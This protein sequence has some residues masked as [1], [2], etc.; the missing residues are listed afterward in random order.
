[1]S[2]HRNVRH[3]IDEDDY[4]DDNYDDDDYYDEDYGGGGAVKAPKANAKAKGNAAKANS[5]T[6][7]PKPKPPAVVVVGSQGQ[8]ANKKV[9][10]AAAAAA[11]STISAGVTSGTLQLA[12]SVTGIGRGLVGGDASVKVAAAP[13]VTTASAGIAKPPPGFGGPPPP[14]AAAFPTPSETSA[15]SSTAAVG[16]TKISPAPSATT[17]TKNTASSKQLSS[18]SPAAVGKAAQDVAPAQVKVVT[19]PVPTILLE[20][21]QNSQQKPPLTLVVLGHV[22]AGKSTL[23][24]HLLHTC[25]SSSSSP[26]GS[27]TQ[28][29]SKGSTTALKTSNSNS[30]NNSTNI[31]FAWLLD[32]DEEERSHGVTMDIST[33]AITTDKY[34]VLLLDA[35]GHADYVPATITGVAAADGAL[36]VVDASDFDTAFGSG[37]L[38][39]HLYLCR[40]LGVQQILCV[41]NKMDACQPVPFSQDVYDDICARLT[42]F[43]TL[44]AGYA[45]NKIRFVPCAG[46]TGVNLV[47]Q[48]PAASA[49]ASTSA[50]SGS[51]GKGKGNKDKGTAAATPNNAADDAALLMS[52]YKGPTV[53]QALDGFDSTVAQS[54]KLQEQRLSKPLRILLQDVTGEQGKGVSVRAK[55]VQGWV[56]Q[57]ESV[58]VLPVGDTAVISKLTSLQQSSCSAAANDATAAA[59]D[60]N[61]NENDNEDSITISAAA[62]KKLKNATERQKYAVAGEMVDLVVTGVDLVRLSVGSLL[63]RA[64]QLPVMASQCRAKVWI[65]EGLSIPIIRGASCI[66]HMH[67]LDVPCHLNQLLRTLQKDGTTAKERPRVL[68]ANTQAVIEIKL[69]SPIVMEAFTDCRALGR[70]VL[71]RGGDTIGVGR[72]EQVL[73]R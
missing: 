10:A 66:F 70:F 14:R 32:T 73:H 54:E 40:G 41:V 36:A 46:L 57:G 9:A 20:A 5:K 39:E 38:R 60:D 33:Q 15:S 23:T 42:Q 17:T 19:P 21:L 30:R 43:L 22:D 65:L 44:S 2:R 28:T 4:Y 62:S 7:K 34:S 11:P 25:S 31:N 29:G 56:Q 64:N 13:A 71:R 63:C 12:G 6:V 50:V 16:V 61:D 58:T 26:S 47:H 45:A 53:W 52:W 67:Q 69:S 49:S 24:G 18:S 37:Q 8:T 68:T 51:G 27:G 1:M 72:I 48:Y 3:L 59:N 55:I 35:P